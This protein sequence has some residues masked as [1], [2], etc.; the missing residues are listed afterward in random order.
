M[1]LFDD[2][3]SFAAELTE[4]GQDDLACAVR[5]TIRRARQELQRFWDEPLTVSEAAAWG[6]YSE[7]QLRRLVKDATVAITSDGR[8]RR[9]HV[10]VKPGHDA[11]QHGQVSVPVQDTRTVTSA[12]SS[13]RS[14]STTR[15]GCS[16]P[17]IRAYSSQ[18]RMPQRYA[19]TPAS[20]VPDPLAR[21]GAQG[22]QMRSS[23]HSTS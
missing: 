18:S 14:T 8:I 1:K 17:R 12:R 21:P 3:E 10:P 6:D 4:F 5:E 22:R 13:S 23:T 11:P 16:I 19:E 7:S 15:H 9:R 2:L 20:V